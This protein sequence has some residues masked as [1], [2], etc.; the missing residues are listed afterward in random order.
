MNIGEN[1][2]KIRELKN[3]SQDKLSKL[4]NMPR[5]SLGRYERGERIPNVDILN[6]IACSLDVDIDILI[7]GLS[8]EIYDRDDVFELYNKVN[9]KNKLSHFLGFTTDYDSDFVSFLNGLSND[10]R[11]YLKLAKYLNLTE[12]NIYNWL[13]SDCI[14]IKYKYN[15]FIDYS[16]DKNDLKY[17]IDKNILKKE[18]INDLINKNLSIENES[19]LENY[20]DSKHL[21]YIENIK[22]KL[23]GNKKYNDL[24]NILD[25]YKNKS[26]NLKHKKYDL[27]IKLLLP[28][29]EYYGVYFELS[30]DKK[31]ITIN[32]S[33]SNFAKDLDI[34]LFY[35]FIDKVHWNIANEMNYL[36]D[37]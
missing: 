1:I 21:N 25:E 2:K 24:I 34:N 8:Y 17:F 6:K 19:F 27:R 37:L 5:T 7:H 15:Q 10:M 3:I 16:I 26:I 4:S 9:K 11:L 18:N 30:N 22:S 28:I 20:F 33:G 32:I 13:L 23:N 36:K 14:Y 31:Y 12:K 29:F 35:N